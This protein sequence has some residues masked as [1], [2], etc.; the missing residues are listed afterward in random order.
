MMT[1]VIAAKTNWKYA[2]VAIG[3]LA[4][5]PEAGK[6][7]CSISLSMVKIGPGTPTKGSHCFPNPILYAHRTQQIMTAEKA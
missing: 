5:T 2:I 4:V 1:T 6:T 3:K 7:A